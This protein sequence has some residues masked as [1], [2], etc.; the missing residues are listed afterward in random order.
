[1]GIHRVAFSPS[2]RAALAG[3]GLS[4]LEAA[5][6]AGEPLPAECGGRGAADGAW[7]ASGERPWERAVV[8]GN[9]GRF[10]NLPA[11][12]GIGLLPALPLGRYGYVGNGSL[13]GARLARAARQ[14][15][16]LS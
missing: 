10:L 15:R 11:A 7:R 8:S 14:S 9:F 13:E 1:M 16:V 4:V 12:L 6:L 5:R 2:G 3:D